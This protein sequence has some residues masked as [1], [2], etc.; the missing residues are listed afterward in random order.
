MICP[1]DW[2]VKNEAPYNVI[3]L[4]GGTDQPGSACDTFK[5]GEVTFEANFP[6]GTNIVE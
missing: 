1:S 3:E 2:L 6:C 5:S 4:Q